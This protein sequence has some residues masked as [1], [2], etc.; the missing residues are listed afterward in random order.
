MPEHL[1][2]TIRQQTLQ[3]TGRVY[4]SSVLSLLANCLAKTVLL[5]EFRVL[6]L[7]RHN[8]WLHPLA[9]AIQETEPKTS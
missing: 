1:S 7:F 5:I 2:S 4:K 8:A 9:H 6:V 3:D